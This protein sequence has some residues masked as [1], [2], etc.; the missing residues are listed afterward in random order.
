[1]SH[2][3]FHWE[4]LWTT[5]VHIGRCIILLNYIKISNHKDF[6]LLTQ[7]SND[8]SKFLEYLSGKIET[9]AL[10]E[11]LLKFWNGGQMK[12]MS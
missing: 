3:Y 7:T 10:E 2:P 4:F 1:M 5:L 6:T 9:S 8:F 12:T 11:L